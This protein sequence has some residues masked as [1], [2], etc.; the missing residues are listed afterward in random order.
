MLNNFKE[1]VEGVLGTDYVYSLGMWVDH[2]G[3]AENWIC[4]IQKNSG[5]GPDVDDRRQRFRLILLGP[6]NGRNYSSNV[7][8]DI[9]A[10]ISMTMSGISPC[11]SANIRSGEAAGPGYTSEDRAWYSLDFEVLF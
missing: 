4:S 7:E 10:L 5:P 8:L 2:P 6:A 11:G 1:W 3:V 9:E